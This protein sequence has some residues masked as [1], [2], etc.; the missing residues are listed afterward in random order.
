[1]RCEGHQTARH[2]RHAGSVEKRKCCI[3]G[4][5]ETNRLHY[6]P[7][8]CRDMVH[9]ARVGGQSGN[10]LLYQY[11]GLCENRGWPQ[12]SPVR[13]QS[14]MP[15]ASSLVNC[16]RNILHTQRGAGR[17]VGNASEPAVRKD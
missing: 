16:C 7:A 2:E 13:P 6:A 17:T 15:K 11:D 8:V 9:A 10:S 4:T 12:E 14:W 1:V 3:A 5:L